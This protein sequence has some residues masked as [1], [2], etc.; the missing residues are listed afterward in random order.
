MTK[1]NSVYY[2]ACKLIGNTPNKLTFD[3]IFDQLGVDL[4]PTNVAHVQLA[5]NWAQQAHKTYIRRR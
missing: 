2:Q 3:Q 4:N 1:S 5:L